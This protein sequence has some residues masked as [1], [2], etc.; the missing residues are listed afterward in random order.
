MESHYTGLRRLHGKL[1]ATQ[2]KV[3][4]VAVSIR[5]VR[6]GKKKQPSYRV[7][8]ADRRAPRNGRFI[9]ILGQ[10]DPRHEPSRV[11]IDHDRTMYW[12]QQ[13]AQTTQAIEKVLDQT[14][15]WEEFMGQKPTERRRGPLHTGAQTVRKE[16]LEA[17]A[18]AK[19]PEASEPEPGEP[20]ASEATEL[21]EET[22]V[23]PETTEESGEAPVEEAS[24][25]VEAESQEGETS[26]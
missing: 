22:E 14:G 11:N 20:E 23:T 5:L 4:Y 24:E 9:E 26:E 7:V 16:I 3:P 8:V 1:Q 2:R 12:L 13:G 10:F 6:V 25:S 18:K 15:M 17:E 21:S 19:E